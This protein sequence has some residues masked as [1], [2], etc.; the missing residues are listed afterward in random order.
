MAKV[1]LTVLSQLQTSADVFNQLVKVRREDGTEGTLLCSH[2]CKWPKELIVK[3]TWIEG[4]YTPKQY[5]NDPRLLLG[6]HPKSVTRWDFDKESSILTLTTPREVGA[7]DHGEITLEGVPAFLPMYEDP[8]TWEDIPGGRW[9]RRLWREYV[10]QNTRELI[11]AI[12]AFYRAA[13]ALA[14]EGVIP[15]GGV[16]AV[17]QMAELE[18]ACDEAGVTF[19]GDY[20]I[21]GAFVPDAEMYADRLVVVSSE[22]DGFAPAWPLEY[23][24]EYSMLRFL[25]QD[26]VSR[27]EEYDIG[28]TSIRF[29]HSGVGFEACIV[30]GQTYKDWSQP[31]LYPERVLRIEESENNSIAQLYWVGENKFEWRSKDWPEELAWILI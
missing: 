18:D 7:N 5:E 29:Y 10:Q 12:S 25:H 22:E 4:C 30:L 16:S 28:E 6:Y 20:Q 2:C 21:W 3:A 24:D 27:A 31:T 1:Q 17:W 9:L 14:N 11:P 26:A 23:A 19:D 8:N 13:T 15:L